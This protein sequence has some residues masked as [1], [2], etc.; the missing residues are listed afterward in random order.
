MPRR[1]DDIQEHYASPDIVERVLTAVAQVGRP[2]EPLSAEMLY[3]FDQL[4]GR[5]IVATREHV[6]RLHL[7]S[8]MHVL[9]VGSGIGGPARYIAMTHDVLVTGI[10]VTPEFVVT[11]RDLTRRCGL[12]NRINFHEA[13]ALAMPFPNDSFDAALCL[14][15]AM[16]IPDKGQLCREIYRVLRPGARL[17][18]SEVALGPVGPAR[19]PLPWA[20][21]P[22][23]NFLVP[24]QVLRQILA[25]TGFRVLNLID[26]SQRFIA[27]PAPAG[28]TFPSERPTANQIVMGN[29]FL[30]RREN[31]ILNLMEGR[32]LSILIEAQ[33]A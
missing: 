3:Q 11:A 14:Y 27:A 9:D 13:D 20:S 32:L 33:K 5:E 29:D 25:K 30:K 24:P 12:E 8:G 21:V 31:L 18:W 7:R 4:H 26:E 23:A 6:A 10:D 28:L 17:V 2:A 15:V 16:N 22:A 1:R 19:F